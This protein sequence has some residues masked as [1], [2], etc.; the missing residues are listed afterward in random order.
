MRRFSL[1]R[2]ARVLRSSSGPG[3]VGD[4][5]LRRCV[6]RASV[7]FFMASLVLF[8]AGALSF[9]ASPFRGTSEGAFAF[10]FPFALQTDSDTYSR[11]TLTYTASD[12]TFD[13]LSNLGASGLLSQQFDAFGSL[14][15][16]VLS[17]QLRFWP[18]SG[19]APSLISDSRTASGVEH[20]YDLGV[21]YF[22]DWVS[23][24]SITMDTPTTQWRIKT[25]LDG[26][27]WDWVSGVFSGNVPTGQVSVGAIARYASI[28]VIATG[29]I[30]ASSVQMSVSAESWVTNARLVADGVTLYGTST[31]ATGSSGFSLGAVGSYGGNLPIS[32]TMSFVIGKPTCA[33]CF[34]RFEGTFGFSVGCLDLVTATLRMRNPQTVSQSAFEELAL[35]VDG[36]YIGLP[37]ITLDADIVFDVAEKTITLTPELDLGA[38]NC[39]TV[40]A[41][42]AGGTA[43]QWDI[44]G[45]SVYGIRIVYAWDGVSFESLSYLD[46]LHFVKDT[47][48]EA[49]TI[50]SIGDTC[51]GSGLEFGVSTYFDKASSSLFGWAETEVSVSFGVAVGLTIRF[52]MDV[53]PAGLDGLLFGWRFSW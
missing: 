28:V 31:I 25:S 32:G 18:L 13:S 49:L 29:H 22:V 15:S 10:G 24:T 37:S 43:D 4:R 46:G 16:V 12:W 26:T 3:L 41:S 39:L 47:S 50:T 53:K 36:L 48:W 21:P 7:V 33:L 52:E 38:D 34:D 6:A 11:L 1:G 14:G 51:C 44:T 40:Y 8:A 9:G 30:D 45:L 27:T 5:S 2:I 35:S 19:S 23:V 42:L 20:R 17:S